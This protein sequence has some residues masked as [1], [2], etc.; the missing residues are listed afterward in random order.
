MTPL[1][2]PYSI[3]IFHLYDGVGDPWQA[4][5]MRESTFVDGRTVIAPY[6]EPFFGLSRAE[7]WHKANDWLIASGLVRGKAE[8]AA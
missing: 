7:A 6:A 8:A 1:P 5:V 2:Y 3:N 4:L